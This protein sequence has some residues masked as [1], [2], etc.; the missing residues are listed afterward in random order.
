MKLN[1][2]VES[3]NFESDAQMQKKI[4]KNPCNLCILGQGP[5][6]IERKFC[7]W[8]THKE[9]YVKQEVTEIKE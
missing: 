7:R 3:K 8:I 1:I 2:I 4:E 9:I 5:V 6:C